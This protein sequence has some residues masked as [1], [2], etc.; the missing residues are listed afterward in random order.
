MKAF[1]AVVTCLLLSICLSS[2]S[3]GEE[4]GR[5]RGGG[6]NVEFI[7]KTLT[8]DLALNADQK[9]KITEAYDKT[10]KPIAEK[11]KATEDQTARR[12]MFK[13]L[14]AASDTFRA[15]IKGVLTEPQNAKL[16]EATAAMR[17]RAKKKKGDN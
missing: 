15:E 8:G 16:D 12:E 2:A 9:T 11:M 1:Y 17:D 10:V 7:E 3:A 6:M 14:R 13:D 4:G 5:R